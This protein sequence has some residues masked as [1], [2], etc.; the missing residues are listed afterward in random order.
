MVKYRVGDKAFQ[1]NTA[2]IGIVIKMWG[3]FPSISA[4]DIYFFKKRKVL[5]IDSIVLRLSRI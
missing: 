3:G 1:H 4:H 5:M 2:L